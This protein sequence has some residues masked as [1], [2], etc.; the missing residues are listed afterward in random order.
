MLHGV[1][2]EQLSRSPWLDWPTRNRHW[3]L[4]YV[5]AVTYSTGAVKVG[6]TADPR[7]RAVQLRNLA[8]Q[9]GVTI[10]NAWLSAP[11][12]EYRTNEQRLHQACAA[13]GPRWAVETFACSIHDVITAA[14]DLPMT[15]AAAPEAMPSRAAA[16]IADRRRRAQELRAQGETIRFIA[17][18]LGVSVAAAHGYCRA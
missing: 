13:L 7:G 2:T 12:G 5:Y 15:S 1:N 8:A 17:E 4:G 10:T 18:E 14:R 3:T 6:S 11:H 16:R 9:F